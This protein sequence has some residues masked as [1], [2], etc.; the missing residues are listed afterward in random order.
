MIE[1]REAEIR[2]AGR[3]LTGIVMAYDTQA[4]DRPELFRA[5]A[6][7]PLPDDVRL[8][9]QHDPEREIASLGNGLVLQDSPESLELRTELREGS[10]ELTLVRRGGLNGLSVEFHARQE[11][12]ESG[13]RVIERAELTG[14]G[15]VDSPSYS[16]SRIELRQ[17]RLTTLRG[18]LNEGLEYGCECAPDD[19][20]TAVFEQDSLASML[21]EDARRD[22]LAVAGDYK[23]ALA[24]RKVR[25]LRFWRDRQGN[26][27]Y[28]LDLPDTQA[29]RDILATM[30]NAP[31]YGRPIIDTGASTFTKQ[32][33]TAVYSDV[34]ARGLLIGATDVDQNWTPLR[35]RTDD[36]DDLP[37]ATRA[38]EPEQRRR[39]WL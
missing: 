18:V 4:R 36:A 17:R 21:N 29:A 31:I 34:A 15:L 30:D 5:G 26:L 24:S 37:A 2:L 12:R 9:I 13:I 8:N 16:R 27:Q 19:C 7:D 23:A 28:A 3:N 6:F 22:L 38:A 1:R 10:A 35:E 32:G 33:T 11:T 39:V 20:L 25:T 14:I